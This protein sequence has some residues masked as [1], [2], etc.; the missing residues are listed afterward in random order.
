[1]R[2]QAS[3]HVPLDRTPLTLVRDT[4]PCARGSG[5]GG[6][7]HTRDNFVDVIVTP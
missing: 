1:M 3:D 7:A 2:A 6:L 4:D 5:R